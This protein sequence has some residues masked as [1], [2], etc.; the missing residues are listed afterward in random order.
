M[1]IVYGNGNKGIT[2]SEIDAV[3][4]WKMQGSSFFS[5]SDSAT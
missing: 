2:D 5:V 3:N 1:I 4:L